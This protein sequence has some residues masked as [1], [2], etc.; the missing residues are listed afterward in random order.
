[1]ITSQYQRRI[2]WAIVIAGSIAAMAVPFIYSKILLGSFLPPVLTQLESDSLYYLTIIKSVI[3]GDLWAGNPYILEYR[4]AMLP[5]LALP[6]WMSAVPGWL[7]LSINNVLL[8]NA[9]LY[10]ALTGAV[11]YAL[12]L[13]FKCN[14]W[15]AAAIAVVGV[16]SLSNLI[17]RPALMQTVYP[18]FGLF[19]LSLLG[20]LEDPLRKIRYA[21][22]G[23]TTAISFYLYPHLWTQT[24]SAVGVFYLWTLYKKDWRTFKYLTVMGLG[25]ILV[26]LPQILMTAQMFADPELAILSTR[27]GLIETHAVLPLTVLNNKYVILCIVGLLL[28]HFRRK[29]SHAEALLLLLGVAILMSAFSNVITGKEIDAPTHPWRPGLFVLIVGIMIFIDSVKNRTTQIEKIIAGFCLSALVFTTINRTFIRMN[30]YSYILLYKNVLELH[31]LQRGYDDVFEFVNTKKIEDSVFLAD[32]RFSTLIPLYTQNSILFSKKAGLHVIPDEELKERFLVYYVNVFDADFMKQSVEALR[33]V[34]TEHQMI[35]ANAYPD[36]SVTGYTKAF[37]LGLT[38]KRLE[39]DWPE[40]KQIDFVGGD[41]FID[42]MTKR[43]REINFNYEKYL[44]KYNVRYIIDDNERK[45][46]MRIPKNVSIL[47]EDGRYTVYEID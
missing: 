31:E 3:Q 7:G 19:M 42:D 5:T 33:G 45:L 12:N 21:A 18:I 46:D 1:M 6:L 39:G 36:H 32:E 28:L 4:N 38:G 13:K 10:G 34:S 27:N 26:C 29:L 37:F 11:L 14:Q 41:V 35:Y 47:Y 9:L 16:A 20:V 40:A 22:L 2:C 25:I 24:F 15:L 17:F 44:K 8:V 30:S 23:A 43:H